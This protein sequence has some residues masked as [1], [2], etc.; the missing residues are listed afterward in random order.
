MPTICQ[1]VE[2]AIIIERFKYVSNVVRDMNDEWP[3]EW[4][5]AS[6]KQ[7]GNKVF[8]DHGTRFITSG[9]RSDEWLWMVN[10]PDRLENRC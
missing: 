1:L 10:I 4:F 3:G 7:T 5:P 6:K 9:E 2:L 8:N